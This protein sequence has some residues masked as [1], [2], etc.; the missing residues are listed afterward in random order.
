MFPMMTTHHH[1]QVVKNNEVLA[2]GYR[3]DP[4]DK[5]LI[6]DYL[7]N[8]VHG[9]PLPSTTAVKECDVYG[10]SRAWKGLFEALEEDTL[11]FFTR[12]KKKA[13]KGK[14]IDR[15]TDSGTWKG[16]QGDKEIFCYN[17]NQMVHIGSKS[18]FS[19][20]PKERVKES[21]GTWVMHEYRL[22]GCQLDQNTN[23]YVLCRI[24]KMKKKGKKGWAASDYN[25]DG[26]GSRTAQFGP[27]D[28]DVGAATTEADFQT[29]QQA[30][31]K[32]IF[33]YNG[34]PMV[35]IGS[36]N[37]FSFIPKLEGIHE[38]KG[39]GLSDDVHMEAVVDTT[40]RDEAD[41][42]TQQVQVEVA[43][44]TTSTS[45]NNLNRTISIDEEIM[46]YGLS[47]IEASTANVES[48]TSLPTW[49][50]SRIAWSNVDDQK[51]S[52]FLIASCWPNR[53]NRTI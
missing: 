35:H 11:Y 46:I 25:D 23:S 50:H 53:A 17:G 29:H 37:N 48:L 39:Y 3:F 6:V 52:E 9:N 24:K 2:V 44:H 22:K 32:E 7:F 15:V 43:D 45:N 13:E 30:A 51:D 27:S 10:D 5:E 41:F 26:N 31:E 16:Q 19:F 33:S 4:T 18:N 42:E 20:I 21:R 28:H 36:R 38:T 1:R 49:F 47:E 12:L 8:K 40:T 34:N 14:R